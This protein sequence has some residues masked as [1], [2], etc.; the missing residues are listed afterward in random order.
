MERDL[1]IGVL[2]IACGVLTLWLLL[3]LVGPGWALDAPMAVLGIFIIVAE[4]AYLVTV[5]RR[6]LIV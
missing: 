1:P 2:I 6:R 3:T 4:V 5:Y